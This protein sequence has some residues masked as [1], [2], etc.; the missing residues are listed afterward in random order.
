[1]VGRTSGDI[2]ISDRYGYFKRVRGLTAIL[3]I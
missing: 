1:M 3:V 2:F